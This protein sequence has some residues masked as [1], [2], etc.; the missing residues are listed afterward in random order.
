MRRPAL[1]LV[2]ALAVPAAAPSLAA[3]APA[4][5]D[6]R[7]P[8][9]PHLAKNPHNNIHNDTWMT[10][11]YA[12]GGPRGRNLRTAFGPLT[13]SICGSLT[14]D[15]R[16]RIVDRLPVAH[17]AAQGCGSSTPTA[18]SCWPST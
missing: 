11:T 3:A 15:R 2:L 7:A 12:I 6:P 1:V 8:Q 18:S 17:R 13:A 10:D 4:I 9:N 16:G 14:F 5:P